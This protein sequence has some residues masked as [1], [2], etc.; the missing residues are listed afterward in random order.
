MTKLYED[1]N[2]S[3]KYLEGAINEARKQVTK[4]KI[5]C[6]SMDRLKYYYNELKQRRQEGHDSSFIDLWGLVLESMLYDEVITLFFILY[7]IGY[8]QMIIGREIYVHT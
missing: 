5:K 1:A 6:F 7:S 8:R 3:Q 4:C 2:W